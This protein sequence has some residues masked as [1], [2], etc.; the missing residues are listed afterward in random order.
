MRFDGFPDR[1]LSFYEGLSVDNTKAYWTDHKTVYDACVAG[2]MRALL[3]ELEPEFGAAKF[4]RP[5]RDVRFSND[6]APYKTQAAA[7]V[8]ELYI[9]VSADGL[10]VG[11]GY[12]HTSTDQTQRLRAAVDDERTGGALARIVETLVRQGWEVSG[13]QLKRVPKPWD[14]THPRADLIRHKAL[15]AG[16]SE[17]PAEWLHTPKVK[18]RVAKAWRQLAPLNDWLKDNVGPA[19]EPRRR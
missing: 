16:K 17:P 8:G 10:F 6:K 7:M 13:E 4:F 14:D 11:G 9:A 12:Y 18:A 1:M 5:Y 3:D 15:V 19:R 2:P